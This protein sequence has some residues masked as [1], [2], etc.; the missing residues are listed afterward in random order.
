[1][2][3]GPGVGDVANLAN[4]SNAVLFFTVNHS[5]TTPSL[6]N[7]VVGIYDPRSHST[8]ALPHAA[9]ALSSANGHVAI[10]GFGVGLLDRSGAVLRAARTTSS[11]D[12]SRVVLLANDVTVLRVAGNTHRVSFIDASG[13][14]LRRVEYAAVIGRDRTNNPMPYSSTFSFLSADPSGAVWFGLVGRPEVYR[15]P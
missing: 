15:I 11:Y 14:E 13:V 6:G 1:V 3:L 12:E 4:V 9:R 8:I 7:D 2:S 10:A 5:G